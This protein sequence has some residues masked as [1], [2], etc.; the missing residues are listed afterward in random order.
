MIDWKT[1]FGDVPRGKWASE[2]RVSKKGKEYEARYF[3]PEY[4]LL[5]TK[6]NQVLRSRWIP[7]TKKG[8]GRWLGL[9]TYEQPTAW[10]YWPE[11]YRAA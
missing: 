6:C 11:P 4:V 8:P 3:K 1:H 5:S 7:G 2:T 9:A 10:D